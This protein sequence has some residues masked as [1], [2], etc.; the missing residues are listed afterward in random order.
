MQREIQVV[1]IPQ[2]LQPQQ[3]ANGTTVVVD[4]LR[5]TTT[6]I[7]AIANGARQVIPA[8]T[9][10][11]ALELRNTRQKTLVLGG[12]RGGVIIPGFDHGNSPLEFTPEVIADRTLVLCTTNGTVAMEHC[13]DC[14]K[15]LIGAFV[16]LSAIATH[17]AE[18]HHQQ[19]LCSGT[20][21]VITSEDVLFAG[22]LT[23]KLIAADPNAT[24]NDQAQI[25]LG[26]WRDATQTME[27]G[28]PLHL[29][30]AQGAGGRNLMKLGY[31]QDIQFCARID[32][33]THVPV[34]CSQSWS[35]R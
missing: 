20:N 10:P 11:A 27:N 17:L 9:I 23:E 32:Y 26:W 28:T 22:A 1:F 14:P 16:N 24:L 29:L 7:A 21:G 8:G 35:I 15:I 6:I 19:I 13:R 34:L 3:L 2:L 25:A 18:S 31:H 5:A 12:E 4:V 30:L 33:F